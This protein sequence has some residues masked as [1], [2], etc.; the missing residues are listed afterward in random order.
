MESMSAMSNTL[1]SESEI[2]TTAEHLRLCCKVRYRPRILKNKGAIL[3]LTWNFVVF[4]TIS[5]S[6]W[7]KVTQ[8][9]LVYYS[10]ILAVF[11]I[12]I[13]VAGWLADVRFGRYKVICWSMWTMWISAMLL[14]ISYV[15]VD[16][17][18]LQNV[19][20]NDHTHKKIAIVLIGLHAIGTVGFLANIMQFGVDQLPD[21]ST[22]EITSFVSW[23]AWTIVGSHFIVFLLKCI[24][25]DYRLIGLLFVCVSLSLAISSNFIFKHYLIKEPITQNSFSLIFKVIRY[26]IRNKRPRQRSAFTYYE[27]DLP[28]QID[29]GK[30]KYGG[31]FTTEQVED[32]KTFFK[33]LLL[34]CTSCMFMATLFDHRRFDLEMYLT[35]AYYGD[36]RISNSKCQSFHQCFHQNF[37]FVFYCICGMV[38]IP[39]YETLIFPVFNQCMRFRSHFIVLLGMILQ[40]GGYVVNIILTTYSRKVFINN[41]ELLPNETIVCIFHD[42]PPSFKDTIDYKWYIIPEFLF[43]FSGICI[44]KGAL[45]F[46]CA[47]V[48]YTMKGL[49]AGCAYGLTAVIASS[50]YALLY[51]F[52]TNSHIWEKQTILNCEFWYL[53]TKIIPGIIILLMF[54]LAI[55]CYKKRKRDDILPNEHIFAEQYY[56]KYL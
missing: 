2:I 13:P 37:L 32:V 30:H 49:L 8:E 27:D 14:T 11:G 7:D 48:P 6:I 10:L 39:L 35:K 45:E 51:I 34:A 3:A 55:K 53:L 23:C 26:A 29:F 52:K 19:K 43:I 31:P 21:A 16:I 20:I 5:H 40:L 42:S 28:S 38:F 24:C 15:V 50:N 4:I 33:I 56:S 44:I 18:K 41:M 54:I 17:I 25:Q 12:L 22:T 46:Y 9:D 1:T 47:Q 36:I